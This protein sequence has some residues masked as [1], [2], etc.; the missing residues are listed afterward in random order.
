MIHIYKVFILTPKGFYFLPFLFRRIKFYGVCVEDIDNYKRPNDFLKRY[1]H[2]FVINK[3]NTILKWPSIWSSNLLIGEDCKY[4]YRINFD[5]Q[6]NDK[7]I[8]DINHF[9]IFILTK[10]FNKLGWSTSDIEILLTELQKFKKNIIIT[11][12]IEKI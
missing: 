1:L 10:K 4:E 7:S 5:Y 11:R 12:D 6:F 9:F 8:N 3:R 2:K